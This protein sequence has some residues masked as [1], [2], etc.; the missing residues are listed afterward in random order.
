MGYVP[1]DDIVHAQLKVREALYFSA[2]LRTDLTDAEINQRID[3]VLNSLGISDKKDTLIGSPEKKVLSGGQ[4]KRVNIAMELINETPVI[5]LDEPTSGLSSYDA[6]GVIRLLK[7]L[8]AEGK[9]IITTIHQPSLEIFQQFDNLIMIS[10]DRGGHGAL[11]Y[12]GPA[13]PDSI[14]FFDPEGARKA[15]S[16]PGKDLSPEMLLFQAFRRSRLRQWAQ[17]YDHST[18]K[19]QFVAD[20]SGKIP[21]TPSESSKTAVRGIGFGQWMTLVRRNLILKT[22]DKVQGII[23]LIQ[24]PIFAILVGGVFLHLREPGGGLSPAETQHQWQVLG[25]QIVGIEFLMVIAAIWFGCNNVARD[26]VGEWS[27]YQR[28]RMVSLK[29]PFVRLFEGRGR[30]GNLAGAV[31]HSAGDRHAHVRPEGQL[32][33][34][35]GHALPRFDGGFGNRSL[36]LR[37]LRNDGSRDCDAASRAATHRGA[38]RRYPAHA[39]SEG[40]RGSNRKRG[41]FALGFRGELRSRGQTPSR[42]RRRETTY[43]ER[44]RAARLGG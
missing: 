7:Q 1:Q 29:L 40:S 38:G 44:R 8:A 21:S 27:V 22:R 35:A 6:E 16:Q 5:F 37:A 31:C 17:T 10:R 36:H 20:R 25:G 3:K 42:R 14:E 19:K 34:D 28:E 24:A 9:T 18:L 4:R 2:K 12:F 33:C 15:R 41:A 23:L 11:A 43:L 26:I 30:R 13:H 32:L 39:R